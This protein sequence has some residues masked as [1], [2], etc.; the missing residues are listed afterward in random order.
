MEVLDANK[1]RETED[2]CD[3]IVRC[4]NCGKPTK[5]GDTRMISGFVGCDN[6]ITVNG[7]EVECYFE[8][9]MPRV[10]KYKQEY[11]ESKYQDKNNLYHT[12]KVYRWRDN[13]DGGIENEKYI[14]EGEKGDIQ[15]SE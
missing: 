9:L 15:K 2:E 6:I 3:L 10:M 5:Y 7:K 4:N 14:I 13:A 12:G 1:Y 11:Q 8:D